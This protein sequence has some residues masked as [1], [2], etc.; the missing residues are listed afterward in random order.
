M[1]NAGSYGDIILNPKYKD[2]IYSRGVLVTKTSDIGFG[3]NL[4]LPLNRDRNFITNYSD[5]STKTKR[6]IN[7]LLE[8]YN[9]YQ[10]NF[11]NFENIDL[12]EI[13]MFDNFP[14]QI[15]NL[16]NSNILSN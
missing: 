1:I 14:A 10:T 5:F 8:N 7:H 13:E 6:V 12:T 15:F 11:G 16:L 2:R 9:Q 3:Y 4:D